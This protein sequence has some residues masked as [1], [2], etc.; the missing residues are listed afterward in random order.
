MMK[1]SDFDATSFWL[2]WLGG[3]TTAL[4][5]AVLGMLLGLGVF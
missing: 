4:T 1:P 5:G 2:G 3:A